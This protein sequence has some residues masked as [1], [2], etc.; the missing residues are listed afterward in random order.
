MGNRC[1]DYGS[2]NL[3]CVCRIYCR[4]RFLPCSITYWKHNKQTWISN[5]YWCDGSV[6]CSS[7]ACKRVPPI[8]SLGTKSRWHVG[9]GYRLCAWHIA[10]IL[11]NHEDGCCD[12][13]FGT[14]WTANHWLRHR[15]SIYRSRLIVD[16]RCLWRYCCWALSNASSRAAC[17]DQKAITESKDPLACL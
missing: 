7:I 13:W 9:A 2:C 17:W 15:A 5:C 10:Y 16:T 4:L 11:G 1:L 3:W 6:L 14:P 8:P 12:E